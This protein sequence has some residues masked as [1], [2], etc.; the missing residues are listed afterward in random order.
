MSMKMS[1]KWKFFW[2]D[3][4]LEMNPKEDRTKNKFMLR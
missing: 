4:S 3:S 2:T 1:C